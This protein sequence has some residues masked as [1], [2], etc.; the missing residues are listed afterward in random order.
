MVKRT[1]DEA[2][3]SLERLAKSLEEIANEFKEDEVKR[4]V[5]CLAFFEETKQ[6]IDWLRD[7]KRLLEKENEKEACKIL[8]RI[9]LK[10]HS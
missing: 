5:K 10:E 6:M 2:I 8:N 3:N 4:K 9:S 1:I 7:Y